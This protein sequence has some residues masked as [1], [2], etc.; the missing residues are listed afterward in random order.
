V[1]LIPLHEDGTDC[2]QAAEPYILGTSFAC[3]TCGAPPGQRCATICDCVQ[4]PKAGP[5]EHLTAAAAAAASAAAGEP[6]YEPTGNGPQPQ[7]PGQMP[8][9]LAR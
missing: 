7:I 1:T 9:P 4:R 6:P 8:L 5:C 3:P 2:E